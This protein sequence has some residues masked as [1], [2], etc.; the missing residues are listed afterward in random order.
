V[1]RPSRS[2]SSRP[3]ERPDSIS[4]RC[5][6]GGPGM[7][8]SR[9][10]CSRWPG[11]RPAGPRPKKGDRHQWPGHDRLHAP[12]DPPPAG[13]PGPGLRTRPWGGLVLVPVAPATAGPGPV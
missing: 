8:T 6:P 4:T 1:I 12:G 9:C 11:W 7:P 10:P 13:Q 3:R 5:G 2:A